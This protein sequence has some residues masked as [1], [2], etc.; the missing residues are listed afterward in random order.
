MAGHARK[1]VHLPTT[2]PTGSPPWTIPPS[3]SSPSA[4]RPVPLKKQHRKN[5]VLLAGPTAAHSG[6]FVERCC[7]PKDPMGPRGPKNHFCHAR[8]GGTKKTRTKNCLMCF[9]FGPW[10][11]MGPWRPRANFWRLLRSKVVPPNAP[12]GPQGSQE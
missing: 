6:F 10:A 8:G 4:G 7:C 2:S 11:P 12:M 9:F 5:L 3:P 1:T